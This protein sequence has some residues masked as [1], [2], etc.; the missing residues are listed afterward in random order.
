MPLPFKELYRDS[1][2]LKVNFIYFIFALFFAVLHFIVDKPEPLD[3]WG[4]L[5]V[6]FIGDIRIA[7]VYLFADAGSPILS[8]NLSETYAQSANQ[9]GPIQ[10]VLSALLISYATKLGFPLGWEV[11]QFVCILFTVFASAFLTSILSFKLQDVY[12]NVWLKR[13]VL[14]APLLVIALLEVFSY[15]LLF[16]FS[17][18]YWQ[19]SVA[20]LWAAAGWLLYRGKILLPSLFLAVSAGLEAWGL[21]G[22]AMLLLVPTVKRFLLSGLIAVAGALAFWLPFILSGNFT[23]LEHE[24][25]VK[26]ESLWTIFYEPGATFPIGLR[27][28][29]TLIVLSIIISLTILVKSRIG[30][31]ESLIPGWWITILLASAFV[32]ARTTTD[33]VY[34]WYYTSAPKF[35]LIPVALVLLLGKFWKVGIPVTI[36]AYLVSFAVSPFVSLLLAI[37]ALVLLCVAVLLTPRQDEVKP[38]EEAEEI[39]SN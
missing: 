37:L 27:I 6:S 21:F 20:L 30:A 11:F 5:S 32:L 36:A 35:L 16:Y 28:A 12:T 14:A 13:M 24:W 3:F 34:L 23:M 2:F 18:H 17:G 19:I 15:P 10:S 38:Q 39:T 4:N 26:E 33:A 25:Q 9:V 7:D 8:G 31:Y 22:L 29:Q 1:K